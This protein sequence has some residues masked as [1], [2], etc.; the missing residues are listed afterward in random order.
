[1]FSSLLFRFLNLSKMREIDSFSM[2]FRSL[3]PSSLEM[4]SASFGRNVLLAA[5]TIDHVMQRGD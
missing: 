2:D 3:L 5:G 1:M 4:T